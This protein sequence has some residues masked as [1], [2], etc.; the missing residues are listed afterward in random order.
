MS[1]LLPQSGF[2][3]YAKSWQDISITE[4]ENYELVALSV[5]TGAEDKFTKT[6]RKIFECAP[7]DPNQFKKSKHS[8][9]LWSRPGQYLVL[10]NEVDIL[11]DVKIAAQFNETAYTVLQSDGCSALDV[12]GSAVY[13]VLE[14]FIP[15]NLKDAPVGFAARTAAHHI[16]VYI[17]KTAKD[18][19]ILL[20]PR[21][22][23]GSFLEGLVH[24][25]E[26]VI[27]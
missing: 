8:Q 21:S 1:K 6:F 17:L 19:F 3:G 13:D 20:T 12:K 14:R 22:S 18:E 7:P 2:G 26:N 24:T 16:G 23:S 10:Q 11:S 15:L 9:I 27:S 5:A 25:V 4:I